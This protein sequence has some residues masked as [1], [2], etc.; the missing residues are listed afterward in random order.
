MSLLMLEYT[1]LRDTSTR[2]DLQVFA[3][4]RFDIVKSSICIVSLFLVL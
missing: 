4:L 2:R 1:V 3:L